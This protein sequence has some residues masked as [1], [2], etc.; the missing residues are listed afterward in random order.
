MRACSTLSGFPRR[1]SR[2]MRTMYGLRSLSQIP[3]RT[4]AS[5][6]RRRRARQSSQ[7]RDADADQGSR[8][9]GRRQLGVAHDRVV[10]DPFMGNLLVVVVEREI[11]DEADR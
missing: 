3:E 4:V 1:M 5:P 10:L 11:G 9:I 2:R 7:Y 8:R 6:W